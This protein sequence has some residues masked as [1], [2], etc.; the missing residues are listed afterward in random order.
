MVDSW[1]TQCFSAQNSDLRGDNVEHSVQFIETRDFWV[2]YYWSIKAIKKI[3]SILILIC[4]GKYV[5][6]YYITKFRSWMLYLNGL[7][8][9][10]LYLRIWNKAQR[11][12]QGDFGSC[13]YVAKDDNA[14]KYSKLHSGARKVFTM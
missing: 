7:G 6:I 4:C 3:K 5:I 1:T 10:L 12:K 14:I 2:K 8:I 9:L 11:F 13:S